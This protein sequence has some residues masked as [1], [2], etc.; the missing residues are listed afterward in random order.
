[1]TTLDWVIYT[2]LITIFYQLFKECSESNLGSTWFFPLGLIGLPNPNLSF[3][4]GV[5][6][7][8]IILLFL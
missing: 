6:I 3:D 5:D 4:P 8:F 1:M 7:L 2:G